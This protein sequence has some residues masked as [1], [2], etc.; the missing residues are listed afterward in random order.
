M[1]KFKSIDSY[2][3]HIKKNRFVS[4]K[5]KLKDYNDSEIKKRMVECKSISNEHLDCIEEVMVAN[6]LYMNSISYVHLKPTNFIYKNRRYI[7][8]FTIYQDDTVIYLDL[9]DSNKYVKKMDKFHRKHKNKYIRIYKNYDVLSCLEE[10]L[11]KYNITF[12]KRSTKELYDKLVDT[13]KDGYYKRFLDFCREFIG[14]FKINGNED[15]SSLYRENLDERSKFFLDFIEDVYSYYQ[16]YLKDHNLLDFEDMINCSYNQLCLLEKEN[17]RL[18][19]EYIII[20]EYQDISRQRFNL[21]KKVSMLC[22]AKLTVVGDDWQAIFAFAGSDV[23]LFTDF[24]KNMGYASIMHITNTY[25]N[26]KQLIDI[27]GK[28]VMEN[29]FQIKKSLNSNKS[30]L[31]PVRIYMEE[32]GVDKAVDYCLKEI[33]RDYPNKSVLIIG[34]YSFDKRLILGKLFYEENDK[35]KSVNYDLTKYNVINQSITIVGLFVYF[36]II[37]KVMNGQTF[38]KKIVKIKLVHQDEKQKLGFGNTIIRSLILN[39]IIFRILVVVGPYFL[40]VKSFYY[41]STT[42]SFIESLIESIILIMVVLKKNNRGLHDILAKTKVIDL[43]PLVIPE[44]EELPKEE[45]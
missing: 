38:G 43:N 25:R 37:Q 27:A 36:G 1:F 26:S 2:D 44:K 9:C 17:K 33:V 11:I 13:G 21:A 19:Y 29:D 30:I 28:F 35:I 6:F 10:E 39:N 40:N 12:K 22:Q 15:I 32:D 18:D 24:V 3:K 20:D 23:S 31:K 34:R 42:I 8:S 41:Y 5:T 16:G 14:S 45:K 7:P 4:L